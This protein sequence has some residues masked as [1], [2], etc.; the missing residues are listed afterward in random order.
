MLAARLVAVFRYKV[1]RT[2]TLRNL[3]GPSGEEAVR[4]VWFAAK[5]GPTLLEQPREVSFAKDLQ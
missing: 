1:Q 2:R 3:L 4:E 5:T